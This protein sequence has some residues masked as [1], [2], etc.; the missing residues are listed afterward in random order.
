M[1][2]VLQ[3]YLHD[4]DCRR[5]STYFQGYSAYIGNRLHTEMRMPDEIIHVC[6]GFYRSAGNIRNCQLLSADEGK[7]L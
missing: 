6:H 4:I 2:H 5:F 3:I 1:L 7:C